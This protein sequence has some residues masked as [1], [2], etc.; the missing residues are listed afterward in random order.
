MD[1]GRGG[2]GRGRGG[3]GGRGR[4]RGGGRGN[5]SDR[6]GGRG[7]RG[8]RGRGG[9]RGAGR[10]GGRGR[11][12]SGRSN[13]ADPKDENTKPDSSDGGDGKRKWSSDSKG[14]GGRGRGRGRGGGK[15][16]GGRGNSDDKGGGGGGEEDKGPANKKR[17]LKLERQQQRPQFNTV[18]RSKEI[19]NKLR[20]RKVPP[21]ERAKLV[22][23]LLQLIKGKVMDIALKHDASRVVQ[24][25]L[26]FGNQEERLSI[27]TEIEGHIAQLSQLTYAHFIVLRLFKEIKGAEEQKRV[28]KTFRG[29]T[30][31][32]ATHA[33]GARVVQT[34]LDSLPVASAALIK[35]EFYG[36]EY[37]L[38]T[39][40]NQPHSL[41]AVLKARP[42]RRA[43]VMAHVNGVITKLLSK[44]LM[45]FEF[46]HDLLWEYMQEATPVQMQELVPQLVDSYM[47]LL[48]TRPGSMAAAMCAAHG[49]AKERKRMMRALK[50]YV[51]A[52]LTHSDV[53][54]QADHLV[55]PK[56]TAAGNI[57]PKAGKGTSAEEWVP[58]GTTAPKG[59]P[60]RGV[61]AAGDGVTGMDVEGEE[62]ED[63]EDEDEDDE[64]DEEKKKE[65]EE[66]GDAMEEEEAAAAAPPGLPLVYVMGH[67][68]G[69]KLLLR[70]LAP[71]RT[72]YAFFRY[73]HPEELELLKPTMVPS[74]AAA[75]AAAATTGDDDDEEDTKAGG[76]GTEVPLVPSSRKE[77]SVRRR[78][79]LAYLREPLRE[80]CATYAPMLM[81]SKCAGSV[82]L[83]EAIRAIGTPEIV[84]AVVEAACAKSHVG[85]LPMHEDPSAHL[86]MKQLLEREAEAQKAKGGADSAAATSDTPSFADAL[87][88]KAGGQLS[89]WSST[90][91]GGFV[92]TALAE[93]PSTG[94]AVREELGTKTA[95]ARLVKEATEGNNMG[96]KVL[97]ERLGF[98]DFGARKKPQP[99]SAG[100]T[101]KKTR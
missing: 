53:V 35:S 85:K 47:L 17:K 57:V 66:E 100:E 44:G 40:D 73:L 67:T 61:A 12:S 25:A 43:V 54:K 86:F 65:K 19:W 27:L 10:G 83:L 69:C 18:K 5:S 8:G 71:D 64:D 96:T 75:K 87:L 31:K 24:T 92:V 77:A 90:N 56:T 52:S 29:Q 45:K 15:A 55:A 51:A 78:E 94:A 84:A 26:Q 21:E 11:G 95:R 58:R 59:N 42:D 34:A 99:R 62:K 37:A 101:G 98:G 80:A 46:A 23:E 41:K 20:E 82:V 50:G 14:A 9:G 7:G 60:E 81:R 28:A 22:Q 63:E 16:S 1:A 39:D 48:S 49:G 76:Q 88:E 93:V 6:G 36:K 70:L 38:F 74:P 4:G 3:R 97:A 30:V 13:G 72:G 2:G 68:N 79:L 33:I 91:R 32:L 89:S